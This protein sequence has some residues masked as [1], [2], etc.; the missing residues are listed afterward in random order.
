MNPLMKEI[1]PQPPMVSFRQPPNLKR[2]LCRA[3]VP[4]QIGRINR[5]QAGLKKCNKS[6]CRTCPFIVQS[7][8]VNSKQSNTSVHLSEVVDCNTKGVV[9]VIT[10]DKCKVQYVGQTSR[11]LRDRF[12]EH[13]GYIR[14]KIEATGKHFAQTNHTLAEMK[15]QIIKCVIP[16]TETLRLVRESK[17]IHDFNANNKGLNM[18]N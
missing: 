7:N 4:E 17:W 16:N 18:I 5:I 2:T 3:K 13:L 11:R 8:T 9:Y 12:V 10:C 6:G 1:F 15:V 14:M